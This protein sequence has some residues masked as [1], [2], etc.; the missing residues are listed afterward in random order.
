MG[1]PSEVGFGRI[2]VAFVKRSTPS[3]MKYLGQV[4]PRLDTVLSNVRYV[5]P[6]TGSAICV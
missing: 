3:R 5:P 6:I 1:G 4:P 2:Q